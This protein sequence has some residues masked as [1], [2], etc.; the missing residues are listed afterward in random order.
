MN[1]PVSFHVASLLKEK[2]F[3]I[4]VANYYLNKEKGKFIHQGFEDDYWGDN[5]VVNWNKDVVGIKPFE[6]FVSA[7]IIAEAIMWLF[8]KKGIWISVYPY[9]E[10]RED[11]FSYLLVKRSGNIRDKYPY[12]SPQ[13]AYS[14]AFDFILKNDLI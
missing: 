11:L 8:E 5:R 6:G 9:D 14:A 1:K 4:P 13:E 12:K 7:P 2:G 3:N 10:A